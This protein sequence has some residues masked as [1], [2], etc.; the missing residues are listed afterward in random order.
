MFVA[1]KWDVFTFRAQR[2]NVVHIVDEMIE[3]QASKTRDILEV[4]A[5]ILK[6]MAVLGEPQD[7]APPP[8][9][10]NLVVDVAPE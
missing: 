6:G 2:Q 8:H 9:R 10:Q 3:P 5:Y 4:L 1:L 7:Q